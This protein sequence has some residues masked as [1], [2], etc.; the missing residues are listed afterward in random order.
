MAPPMVTY[1]VPGTTGKNHPKG[2]IILNKSLIETPDSHLTT[3]PSESISIILFK[4]VV[5]SKLPFSFK[6]TSP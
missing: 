4:L 5:T 2:T 3:P 1:L 6:Q